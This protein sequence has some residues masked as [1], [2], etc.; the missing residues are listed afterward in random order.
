MPLTARS[1]PFANRRARVPTRIRLWLFLAMFRVVLHAMA[2]VVQ[3]R[4]KRV[5]S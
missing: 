3:D 5:A 2:D 1:I 4:S